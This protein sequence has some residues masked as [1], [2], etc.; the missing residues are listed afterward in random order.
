MRKN[1]YLILFCCILYASAQI[2]AQNEQVV[3]GLEIVLTPIDLLQFQMDQEFV[4]PIEEDHLDH[5]SG[6]AYTLGNTQS[7]SEMHHKSVHLRSAAHRVT[8]YDD[9]RNLSA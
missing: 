1:L 2:H 6:Y 8:D 3:A 4:F 9:D 7:T 5:A